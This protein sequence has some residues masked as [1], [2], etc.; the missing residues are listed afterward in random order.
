MGRY[1]GPKERLSRR[2]G[3][4]LF[5]KGSRSFSAKAGIVKKPYA[6]GQHGNDKKPRLSNYGLQLREKQKVKRLYGMREKQFSNL[7][8]EAVRIAKLKKLDRG[9]VLLRM[10]EMRL[11]NVLYIL[12]MAPSKG[13]ARQFTTHGHVLLNGKKFNI[14]S[15]TTKIGDEISLKNMKL[16]PVEVLVKTPLWLSKDG[17]KGKVIALPERDQVDEGIKENLIIEF[18]SR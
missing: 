16:A 9:L 1:T 2:E 18:Y 13:A 6:P 7:V 5:L 17:I 8:A 3:I 15:Y 14:P 11:D 10:L 4:N 12:G